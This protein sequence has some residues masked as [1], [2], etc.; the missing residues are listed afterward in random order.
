MPPWFAV[1]LGAGGRVAGGLCGL[2]MLFHKVVVFAKLASA[3]V[4]IVVACNLFNCFLRRLVAVHK[5]F[6]SGLDVFTVNIKHYSFSLHSSRAW[7]VAV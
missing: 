6:F 3:F 4:D 1:V 2:L 5:F 7:R